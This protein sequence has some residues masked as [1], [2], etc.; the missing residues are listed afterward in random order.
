MK[1]LSLHILDIVQ[2]SI[3]AKASLITVSVIE[4][5]I[6]DLMKITIGDNGCGMSEEMAKSVLDPFVTSR[7][8]RKVGLGIPL[9]KLAAERCGGELKI[10]SEEGKGTELYASFILS[11]I[12]RQPLGNMKETVLSLITSYEDIDFYYLHKVDE[13]TFEVDTREIKNILG[14]V[15][16]SESEVYL[17]LSEYLAEGEAS[18]LF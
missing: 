2:N 6:K 17:W 11:H 18:L 3:K 12:D 8:T 7:T 5:S 14:G 1:E 9:F 16:F 13:K 10:S 4:D 15:S